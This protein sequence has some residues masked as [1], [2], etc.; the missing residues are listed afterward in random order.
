MT[1][2][3]LNEYLDAFVADLLAYLESCIFRDSKV[4]LTQDYY[5]V[6][7]VSFTVAWGDYDLIE[8]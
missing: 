8:N 6:H 1:L 5:F 7:F 3:M 4:L 2:N